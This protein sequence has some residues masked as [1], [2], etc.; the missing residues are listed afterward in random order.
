MGVPSRIASEEP[1]RSNSRTGYLEEAA[2]MPVLCKP[3]IHP[4]TLATNLR[5]FIRKQR[6]DGRPGWTAA[7]KGVLKKLAGKDYIVY[8]KPEWLLDV[9]WL[10]R[11]TGAI[12]LAVESEWGNEREVLDDFQKLL[13]VKSPL[14]IMI[15]YA[16][17]GSFVARFEKYMKVF[18]QHLEGEN[19]V[20]VEFAAGPADSIYFHNV[21]KGN[22]RHGQLRSVKFEKLSC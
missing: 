2:V 1:R 9:V 7:V 3:P 11:K 15:Y 13:C 8:P 21:R 6:D 20:L 19:Y 10:H 22:L 5:S 12:H 16:Y 4:I 18:D 17:D 14:K